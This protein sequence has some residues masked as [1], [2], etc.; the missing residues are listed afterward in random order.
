VSERISFVALKVAI[1]VAVISTVLLE[2]YAESI[3]VIFSN[4]PALTA[5]ATPS[6]RLCVSVLIFMAPKLMFINMFMGIEKGYLA[7][8]L[9]FFRDVILLIPLL[10]VFSS[11]W[12]FL[13]FGWFY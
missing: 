6:L 4:D 13:E 1:S 9:L 5:I 3:V 12:A 2:I 11:W 8:V 7:M 10:I